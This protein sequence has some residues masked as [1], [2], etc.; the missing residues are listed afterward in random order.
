MLIVSLLL[1]VLALAWAN[2]ANDNLKATATAYGSGAIDYA[3]ARQLATAAQLSGSLASIVLAKALLDA[4]GGKGLLPPE[5]VG[6]PS[7]LVAV[8]AAAAITVLAAT[9]VGL[10][11]ST[12]HALVGGLAGAG[13]VLAPAQLCWSALGGSYFLPLLLTPLMAASAA[14]VVYPLAHRLRESLGIR[15]NSCLCVGSAADRVDVTDQGVMLLRRSE[16]SVRLADHEACRL[17][18]GGQMFGIS[19]QSLVDRLH[20]T[21]A[22]ALGFAR[23]L[24]DT[25]K[26]LALWVA[27]GW[28]G[29]D[30]HFS[31]LVVAATMAAGGWL[32]AQRVAE[33]LAHRIT[34][35]RHG[36]ELLSNGIASS[37]VI[38][39]SLLGSPVSTTHVSAG[40][41][42][43]IGLWND[44]TDWWRVTG[45][46][47]AWITTL[48]FAAAVA[49]SIAW[50]L[51]A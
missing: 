38:G 46:I 45:I 44:R 19:V 6:D 43:G 33:T 1:A 13:F 32:R 36:Q 30:P 3:R 8:A 4:F 15:T 41:V 11:I 23:G 2:G 16:L 26:V 20:V 34:P 21:S 42:F 50:S 10:P 14:G 7:F 22:F 31:L 40:A 12:T 24:N 39:A 37:L 47:G 35:L 48:P 18:Y 28:S 17:I 51:H 9:R 29:L 27:A 25:P 5:V 49:S